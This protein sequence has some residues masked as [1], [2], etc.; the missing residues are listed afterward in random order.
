[1]PVRRVDVPVLIVGA[2]PVGMTASI[3]LARLGIASLVVDRRDGPHRAPQAHVVN[4][5]SLEIFRAMDVDMAALH[6][7]ATPRAD[8]GQVV[9]MTTLGGT[10]LGRMPYE[11]QDDA[12]LALT[13]EPLL[14][15]PQHRL[16]PILVERLARESHAQLRWGHEW[17]A[18]AEDA[19]GVT[20]RVCDLA[21]G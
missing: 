3:L 19:A 13:P 7:A 5:R 11:R 4:P 20:S 18:L 16:E 17:Q 9:W 15:L 8:G 21:S 14:N 1:M 2:G 10:E 12:V 6:A